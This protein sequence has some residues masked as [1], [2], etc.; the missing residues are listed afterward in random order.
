MPGAYSRSVSGYQNASHYCNFVVLTRSQSGLGHISLSQSPNHQEDANVGGSI[1]DG[2]RSTRD[3]NI[4]SRAAGNI[5]VIVTGTVMADVLE[6]LG[7]HGEQ[8]S[9]ERTGELVSL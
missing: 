7:Q 3:R 6:G 5:D 8:L 1:V 4:L 9:I 2:N